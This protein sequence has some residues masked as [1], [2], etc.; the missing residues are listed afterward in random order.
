MINFNRSIGKLKMFNMTCLLLELKQHYRYG[1]AL[2]TFPCTKKCARSF[3]KKWL[4]LLSNR[5]QRCKR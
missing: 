1:G 2:T 5:L 3:L 4:R